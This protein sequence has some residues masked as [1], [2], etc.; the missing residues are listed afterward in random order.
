MPSNVIVHAERITKVNVGFTAASVPSDH[1]KRMLDI[2][3]AL[4]PQAA[5]ELAGRTK[6][7]VSTFSKIGYSNGENRR[8]M[9]RALLFVQD[10]QALFEEKALAAKL[11]DDG[12]KLRWQADEAALKTSLLKAAKQLYDADLLLRAKLQAEM[13]LRE[14]IQ[15]VLKLEVPKRPPVVVAKIVV[16]KELTA[17]LTVTMKQ[18]QNRIVESK[19]GL[20][21]IAAAKDAW[22]NAKVRQLEGFTTKLTKCLANMQSVQIAAT[23]AYKEFEQFFK[24]QGKETE[25]KISMAKKL[26]KAI[27]DYAPFPVSIVGKIGEAACGVLTVDTSISQTRRLGG[28]QYFNSDIPTLANASA[29]ISK[30]TNWATELTRLGVSS[31]TLP[32]STSIADRLDSAKNNTIDVLIK[33]FKQSVDEV[34]GD[35]PTAMANKSTEFYRA[36]QDSMTD[37]RTGVT[38]GPQ[39]MTHMVVNKITALS[40]ATL[41]TLN[42]LGEMNLVESSVLQPFIELQLVAEYLALAAPA[43]GSFDDFSI[44]DSLIKRLESAPHE[45][46]LRKTGSGQSDDIYARHKIPWAGNIRHI[47]AIVIFFRWYAV[48]VNAFDIA[49]GKTDAAT[50]RT[51]MN[52]MIVKIGA[53]LN[54]HKITRTAR[55]D[56]ADWAATQR[57][58]F[59]RV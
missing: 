53:A 47:G 5:A 24:E 37:A 54:T 57:S 26:F 15:A 4:S 9:A 39:L 44:P 3:E 36:V 13:K 25:A 12:F 34:Y 21:P 16:P 55:S 27:A 14:E 49:T 46:I 40:D 56:T 35:S 32:S 59:A 31:S 2:F 43:D 20:T 18:H 48:S 41:K 42:S 1:A 45:L 52:A 51:A 19:G 29:K 6:F 17:L 23:G 10:L 22:S 58:V 11:T 33:V 7:S 28:P 38:A 8:E 50:V 30:V